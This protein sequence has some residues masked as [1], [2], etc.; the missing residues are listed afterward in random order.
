MTTVVISPSNVANFPE[1]GGHFWVYMQYVD[2][3]R[4]LGCDVYWLERFRR[5][6][7]PAA[8]AVTL[9][10]FQA[11]MAR[12]GLSG[13][14]ILYDWPE[15]TGDAAQDPDFMETSREHAYDVFD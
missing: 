8:D 5:G 4:R 15:D 1:G 7:D 6:G 9:S 13:R 2:G 14:I 11:R 12:Y 3:L 10:A